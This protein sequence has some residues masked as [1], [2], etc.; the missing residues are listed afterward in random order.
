MFCILT[1]YWSYHLQVMP[2]FSRLSFYFMVSFTVQ[3]LLY[4]I[5]SHLFIFAFISFALG[6]KLKKYCYDLCQRVFCLYFPLVVLWFP[7]LHLGFL[8]SYN[9]E[10]SG[11]K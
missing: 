3:K 5:R 9:K 8:A 2:L 11:Q 6:D 4:L 1:P 10:L 7:L